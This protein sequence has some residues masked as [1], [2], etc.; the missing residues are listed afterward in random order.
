MLL[1]A[2]PMGAYGPN[3]LHAASNQTLWIVLL[4]I[5]SSFLYQFS[6]K[7]VRFTRDVAELGSGRG[8]AQQQHSMNE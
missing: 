5:L 3:W 2:L 7:L 6:T 4:N 1:P 8:A